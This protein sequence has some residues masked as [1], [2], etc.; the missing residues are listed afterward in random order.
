MRQFKLAISTMQWKLNTSNPHKLEEFRAFFAPYG[1]ELISSHHDLEEIDASPL[2]VIAHK[3]SQV[4]EMTLV[5]DT[6]LEVEGA[7]IG[8]NVRWLLSHL[9]NY[10]GKNATWITYLAYRQGNEVKIY[11]GCVHG[12]IVAPQGEKGF[13]FDK[14]FLPQGAMSTL[15]QAKPDHIN[16][17]KFAVDALLKNQLWQT[18]SPI[19]DWQG[20]WQQ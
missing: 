2:Q 6:I 7:E 3:A 20:P 5:E 19:Y 14:Y 10:I 17:R 18:V 4:E 11:H 9:E 15:A 12:T 13:G 16:A 1:A 8:V